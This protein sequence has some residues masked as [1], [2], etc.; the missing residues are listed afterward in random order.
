L[1]DPTT[2]Y[3]VELRNNSIIKDDNYRDCLTINND[4]QIMFRN[5]GGRLGILNQAYNIC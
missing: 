5:S 1:D 2:T 3:E 4:N